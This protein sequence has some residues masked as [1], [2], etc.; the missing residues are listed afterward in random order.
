[1]YWSKALGET[2]SFYIHYFLIDPMIHLL[3]EL[4]I[5]GM[6]RKVKIDP[7]LRSGAKIQV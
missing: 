1:V 6:K 5:E 4:R 3:G 7:L 2:F